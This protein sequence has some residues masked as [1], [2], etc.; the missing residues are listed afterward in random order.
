MARA[1]KTGAT[2]IV[3]GGDSAAAVAEHGARQRDEPRVH[4][5]RRVARVPR[6]QGSA[7]RRRARRHARDAASRLR[8]ELEDEPRPDRGARVHRRVR[9]AMDAAARSDGHLLSAGHLAHDGACTRSARERTSPSACRTS[10]P[11]TRAPSPAR[12]RRRWRRTPARDTCS[13]ATPSGATCSGRRTQQTAR[14]CAAAARHGLTPILCVGELL[15]RAR[16][17]N[18]RATSCCGSC[19]PDWRSCRA[20]RSCS[21]AIAYEPVWAIGTGKTATP[22]DAADGARRHQRRRCAAGS[23]TPADAVPDSLRRQR[24]QD[25]RGVA[26]RRARTSTACSLAARASTSTSWVGDLRGLTKC[27]KSRDI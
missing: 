19:R 7:G 2:T 9:R 10:A 26:P 17:G 22:D 13:S 23:A 4:R 5:R 18:D 25:E 11:R 3:G 12:R 15:A 14:K 6:R 27:A 21:M 24:E 1:T 20:T 16:S 8:G